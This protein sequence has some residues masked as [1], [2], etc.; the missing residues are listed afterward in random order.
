MRNLTKGI[1]ITLLFASCNKGKPGTLVPIKK[2]FAAVAG[3]SLDKSVAQIEGNWIANGYIEGIKDTKSVYLNR[4]FKTKVLFLNLVKA[5][6]LTGS[7]ILHGFT[8]HEG[9]HDASIKFDKKK[10]TFIKDETKKSQDPTFKDYFELKLNKQNK[11]EI[12]YPLLKE[13]DFYQKLNTDLDTELRKILF[14]GHYIE[15]GS[16]SEVTFTADGAVT[17]RGYV[18]YEVISDF[19]VS[20]DFDG[21]YL[22]KSKQ[23]ENWV[24]RDIYRFKVN[25]NNLELQQMKS[26]DVDLTYKEV[27]IN[28]YSIGIHPVKD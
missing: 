27:G 13:T 9:G 16:K 6:L 20:P 17:F 24:D 10:G 25:G 12:H 5:E 8:D 28:M 18:R 26:N 19:A 1:L 15:K 4:K 22:Y 3:I 14:A 21:I 23:K 2:H 7:A 11:L